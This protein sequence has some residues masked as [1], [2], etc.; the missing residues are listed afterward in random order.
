[1]PTI[2]VLLCEGKRY[3]IGKTN[4]AVDTRVLEHS[5]NNGS[6]W[7]RLYKPIKVV[8]I[9][10]NADDFDEDKYTKMYMIEY[11]IDKVRGGSYTQVHLPDHSLLA[12]HNELCSAANV[13]FRCKRPGHFASQCYARTMADGSIISEVD[14]EE[15]VWVCEVCD[16][17]FDTEYV[18]IQHQKTCGRRSCHRCGRQGHYANQCYA[19]RH[20]NGKELY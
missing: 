1:M 15:D 9:I 11:G 16:K 20:T 18:A 13:C 10:E 17:E 7:T 2:Y 19:S 3:Y 14:E 6:E 12:L 5:R 8:E 4:R